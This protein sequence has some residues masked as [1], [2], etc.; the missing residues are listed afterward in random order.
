MPVAKAFE[1]KQVFTI[2][3]FQ[4]SYRWIK[5][6]IDKEWRDKI[7]NTRL[8][9]RRTHAKLRYRGWKVIR[10]WE[11]QIETDVIACIRKI[12]ASLEPC[13]VNWQEVEAAYDRLPPLKRRN[14]LPKP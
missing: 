5:T 11:H 13:R 10:I 7:A 1:N 8:R 14:R 3:Y 6:Y 12:V 2:P 9:D 4:R